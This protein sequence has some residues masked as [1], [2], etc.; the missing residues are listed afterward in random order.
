MSLIDNKRYNENIPQSLS[1]AKI[2]HQLT[3]VKLHY[4]FHQASQRHI[5]KN[6]TKR[7]HT[8]RKILRRIL[9][10][11]EL[12]SRLLERRRNFC[13]ARARLSVWMSEKW[14]RKK[15][16]KY[17]KKRRKQT[18]RRK[19]IEFVSSI[20]NWFLKSLIKLFLTRWS[21]S[22]VWWPSAERPKSIKVTPQLIDWMQLVF[23][24]SVQKFR[25]FVFYVLFVNFVLFLCWN[26]NK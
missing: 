25:V 1:L 4:T 7:R 8:E 11:K 12:I 3:S 9:Q 6:K 22:N 14:F 15:Q 19:K 17:W 5:K 13:V 18:A 23:L 26:S 21:A 10:R 24:F 20:G 2:S 16:Q